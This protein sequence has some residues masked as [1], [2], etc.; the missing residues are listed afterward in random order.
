MFAKVADRTLREL[1]RMLEVGVAQFGRGRRH[2][3]LVRAR[4]LVSGSI[5]LRSQTAKN[6]TTHR[7]SNSISN[8]EI[9]SLIHLFIFSRY[10]NYIKAEQ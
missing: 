10:N 7:H 6:E 8:S 4:A 5:V 1:E 3:V 2:H 9:I